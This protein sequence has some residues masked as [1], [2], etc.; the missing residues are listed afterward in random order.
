MGGDRL[1]NEGKEKVLTG[2]GAAQG[3]RARRARLE[4]LQ[5]PFSSI[6]IRSFCLL[7]ALER[8]AEVLY[9][10]PLGK[11]AGKKRAFGG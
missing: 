7:E 9:S 3:Q 4:Q 1:L 10:C 6:R 5:E 8:H 11:R 2:G